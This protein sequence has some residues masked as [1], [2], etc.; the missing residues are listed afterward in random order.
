MPASK[1]MS[2]VSLVRHSTPLRETYQTDSKTVK[3]DESYTRWSSVISKSVK[4]YCDEYIPGGFV[5]TFGLDDSSEGEPDSLNIDF[6]VDTNSEHGHKSVGV[7]NI[8]NEC[9]HSGYEDLTKIKDTEEEFSTAFEDF[10]EEK[11]LETDQNGKGDDAKLK[12]IIESDDVIIEKN[13]IK[14]Y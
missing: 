9:I 3:E 12:I 1:D 10:Q 2:V 11:S 6:I 14:F 7:L 4:Y 13:T 5:P 8:C